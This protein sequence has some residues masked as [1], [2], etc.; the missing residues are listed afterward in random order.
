[1]IQ[2]ETNQKENQITMA[3]ITQSKLDKI[4]YEESLVF[5][6]GDGNVLFYLRANTKKKVVVSVIKGNMSDAIESFIALA[7]E[8]PST[9]DLFNHVLNN[10]NRLV[11]EM[12][13]SDDREIHQ[14]TGIT[15]NDDLLTDQAISGMPDDEIVDPEASGDAI[16]GEKTQD[17]P[18]DPILIK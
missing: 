13:R 12:K 15:E 17:D 5:P 18:K 7:L 3:K 2:W 11:E 6:Q 9:I 10:L 14:T 8:R 4:V 1:M 16:F